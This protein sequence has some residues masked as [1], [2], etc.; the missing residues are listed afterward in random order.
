M[1]SKPHKITIGDSR[2]LNRWMVSIRTVVLPRTPSLSNRGLIRPPNRGVMRPV[3]VVVLRFRTGDVLRVF[4]VF[5]KHGKGR[6]EGCQGERGINAGFW[7][8]CRVMPL[9]PLDTL[10]GANA[11]GSCR[12]G[13]FIP[14]GG[15]TA[16]AW[17]GAAPQGERCGASGQPEWVRRPC[18]TRPVLA[19]SPACAAACAVSR[20]RGRSDKRRHASG[21]G[22]RRPST[23]WE[24]RR[25]IH[26]SGDCWS[27]GSWCAPSGRR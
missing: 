16:S 15:L 1:V 7:R 27:A 11:E 4:W 26:R 10:E 21:R 2:P 3:E 14:G 24:T 22:L 12:G 20:R 6:P 5:G 8:L 17:S 19:R 13:F 9:T 25:P 18:P 23:G